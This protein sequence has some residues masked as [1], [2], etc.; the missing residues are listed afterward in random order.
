MFTI[1]YLAHVGPAYNGTEYPANGTPTGDAE[2]F[3]NGAQTKLDA[4]RHRRG[5]ASLADL[6][7]SWDDQSTE[8]TADVSIAEPH[9]VLDLDVTAVTG[10]DSS[11]SADGAAD[12]DAC[13][14][15]PGQPTLTYTITVRNDG[16]APAY[17]IS[18]TDL[19]DLELTD[20]VAVTGA[21]E[22][23]D[24]WTAADPAMQWDITAPLAPGDSLTLSYTADLVSSATL[25]TASTIVNTA[26]V[27]SYFG[28]DST[29]RASSPDHRV[30]GTTFGPV[31][32]DTVTL[33]LDFPNLDLAKTVESGGELDEAMIGQPFGWRVAVTN[34]AALAT[35]SGWTWRTLF[36]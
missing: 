1:D 21:T 3:T 5:A 25:G 33:D 36:L 9:L 28:L 27:P 26:R 30:Y 12:D 34:T 7:P 19:P 10:C 15:G 29:D 6:P 2:T 23:A 17:D 8:A 31:V 18:V 35:A 24:G 13:T 22:L 14:I 20:I 11:H 32:E 4:H 16:S